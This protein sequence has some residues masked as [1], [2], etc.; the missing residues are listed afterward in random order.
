NFKGSD[1]CCNDILQ[2]LIKIIRPSNTKQPAKTR[3]S[4]RTIGVCI[5]CVLSIVN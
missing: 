2:A 4:R 1:C 3:S 5:S